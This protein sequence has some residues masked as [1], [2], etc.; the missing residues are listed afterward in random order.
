MKDLLVI[1][2]TALS[3]ALAGCAHSRLEVVRD[4][5]SDW[6]IVCGM[7]ERDR[8]AADEL[9]EIFE[10]AT[11]VRLPVAGREY[12]TVL[13]SAVLFLELKGSFVLSILK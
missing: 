4:G 2:L 9:A 12:F 10:K 7:G 5:R 3:I 1:V 8:L 11:G 6:Q 13:K